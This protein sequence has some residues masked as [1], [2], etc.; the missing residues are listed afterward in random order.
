MLPLVIDDDGYLLVQVG[1]GGSPVPLD[2]YAVYADA[3]ALADEA[4][5]KTDAEFLAAQVGLLA[6]HGMPGLSARAA[7]QV[8]AAVRDRVAAL[9]KTAG[10]GPTP[11]S[12]GS[13]VP[14]PSDSP[15]ATS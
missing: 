15:P 9:K 12:P 13:T 1:A 2:V 5:G 4:A 10:P 8:L 11:G 7:D 14:P 6:R 3:V